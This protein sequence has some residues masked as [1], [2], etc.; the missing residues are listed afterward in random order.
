MRTFST[1]AG[2]FRRAP[3]VLACVW[4][5]VAALSGCAQH[6]PG[7]AAPTVVQYRVA[8]SPFEDAAAQGDGQGLAELLSATLANR[9]RFVAVAPGG[10]D[11]GAQLLV[12]AAVVAF[13][14]RCASSTV[15]LRDPAQAC[16][17]VDLFVTEAGSGR[18][19]V[20]VTLDASSG[21]AAAASRATTTVLPPGLAAYSSTPMEQAIRNC[22]DAATVQIVALRP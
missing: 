21:D 20:A 1:A 8:V 22:I 7:P 17:V 12:H 5:G 14:P 3:G 16:I 13:E 4:L 15:I 9:G 10:A 11:S 6:P 18:T 19:L 2:R